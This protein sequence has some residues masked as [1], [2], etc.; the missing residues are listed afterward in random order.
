M[1]GS[2]GCGKGPE[3]S[4]LSKKK[5]SSLELCEKIIFFSKDENIIFWSVFK[6][7]TFG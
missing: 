3:W 1:A 6:C 4:T 5:S 2:G 7:S